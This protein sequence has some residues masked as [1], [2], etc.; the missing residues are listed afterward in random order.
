MEFD[1]KSLGLMKLKGDNGLRELAKKKGIKMKKGAGKGDIITAL[2]KTIPSNK[3]RADLNPTRPAP[4]P[5]PGMPQAVADQEI[6]YRFAE[7]SAEEGLLLTRVERELAKRQLM[8]ILDAERTFELAEASE[9]LN[10]RKIEMGVEADLNLMTPTDMNSAMEQARMAVAKARANSRVV[11]ARLDLKRDDNDAT[12]QLG[13]YKVARW[14]DGSLKEASVS[15]G[16]RSSGTTVYNKTTGKVVP[17]K[18]DSFADYYRGTDKDG[19]APKLERI[20]SKLPTRGRFDRTLPASSP[21]VMSYQETRLI[22]PRDKN[23]E[24][25]AFET[26]FFGVDVVIALGGFDENSAPFGP[27]SG[28]DITYWP[29]YIVDINT[30]QVQGRIGVYEV[31]TDDLQDPKN[32]YFD[33]DG[34]LDVTKLEPLLFRFVDKQYL[35]KKEYRNFSNNKKFRDQERVFLRLYG[36]NYEGVR[37]QSDAYA[38]N[39]FGQDEYTEEG[40]TPLVSVRPTFM[41]D[42]IQLTDEEDSSEEEEYIEGINAIDDMI[43]NMFIEERRKKNKINWVP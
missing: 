12:Y 9:Q 19:R 13:K 43:H 31:Y 26:S 30:S 38:A 24:V 7:G 4:P 42:E 17:P 27:S 40:E 21:Q 15:A 33:E 29:I 23:K 22:N 6:K 25:A 32:K 2:L 11:G 18:Y 39:F 41:S 36:P 37:E 34:D 10:I 3:F 16:I 35:E 20:N 5:P 14:A 8:G 28:Y 1:S